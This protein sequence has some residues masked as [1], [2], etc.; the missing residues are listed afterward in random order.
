MDDLRRL[1]APDEGRDRIRALSGLLIGSA[2][3]L[4][5]VRKSDAS[6]GETWGDWGLLL[7]LL[8]AFVFLY[9]VGVLGRRNTDELRPWEST[10]LVFGVLLAPLVLFQFIEA[11]D[12]T[13]G[14]S[15]N[16]FWI[17]LVTAG[18]AAWASLA[19]GVR[20]ALLLASI[21]VIVSWSALWDRI[22]SDGI[23]AHM[24]VYRVVLLVIAAVLLVGAFV[25]SAGNDRSGRSRGNEVVTGASI[26]AVTAGAL[27]FTQLVA[28]SNPLV[29]IPTADS[30]FFW[31]LV[32]L[33]VS[34]AAIAYGSGFGA[35]GTAYVG[36]FGLFAFL[37][38]VGA[39]IN[40]DT[41]QGKLV[42]WPLALLLIG[43]IGFLVSLRPGVQLPR[44]G[45]PPG[46]G[47]QSPPPTT[48]GAG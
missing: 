39:D 24:G 25:V 17:F 28:L 10:Y 23:G 16:V 12:G 3:F 45:S 20:Y 26:A 22:L 6:L 31:E 42:G 8:I 1:F 9:G 40:D 46:S 19:A 11:I 7:T 18:L 47:G 30:S 29:S 33:V 38:L 37:V 14:A 44:R 48:P 21:S 43:A 4:V 32:L 5:F 36:A 27:S 35:R 2:L 15:L 41:P 34:L 13:P